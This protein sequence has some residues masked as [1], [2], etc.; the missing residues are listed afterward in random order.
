MILRAAQ[1]HLVPATGRVMNWPLGFAPDYCEGGQRQ[2]DRE[3]TVTR[4]GPIGL[5]EP[6]RY[7]LSFEAQPI[8]ALRNAALALTK[9]ITAKF[10]LDGTVDAGLSRVGDNQ[11]NTAQPLGPE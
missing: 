6:L 4:D 9:R 5:V 2:P 1:R 11:R 8:P 10:A 3:V 7:T